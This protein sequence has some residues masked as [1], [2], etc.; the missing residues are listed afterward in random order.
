MCLFKSTFLSEWLKGS[1]LIDRLVGAFSFRVSNNNT[2]KQKRSQEGT[3]SPPP[4]CLMKYRNYFFN[5]IF[6]LS[7]N[8]LLHVK[9]LKIG[10]FSVIL[11]VVLN[12]VV[13]LYKYFNFGIK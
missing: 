9:N 4:F 2:T 12:Y 3:I 6:Q 8:I 5:I 10:L 13:V 1:K 11:H 7:Q